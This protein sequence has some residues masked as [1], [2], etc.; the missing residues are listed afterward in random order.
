M[1]DPGKGVA[2]HNQGL[3]PI[4][5]G[6]RLGPY[7]VQEVIGQG[8]MGVVYRA[9]HAELERV[10]AVKVLQA[11]GPDSDSKARFQREAQAIAHM[12]HPNILNV[13]DFGEYGGTPYM[14]VEFVPGG[15]LADRLRSGPVDRQAALAFLRGIAE[16]LDYA[17]S[18]GIVHRDVKP[19]NVLLGP[20]D[21]P[22][23]ADFGLAKLLES[24]SIRSITGITTGT[25]AYMSPEQVT[26]SE[27]GPAADR[28]SLATIAYE[29]FTGAYPFDGEGVLEMLYAHVHRE[30]P[31]PSSRNPEL[32]PGVD[33]VI[34]RGLA[35]NPDERWHTCEA[36]VEALAIAVEAGPAAVARTAT[37]PLIRSVAPSSPQTPQAP[38][39]AGATAVLEPP[40]PATQRVPPPGLERTVAI[41]PPVAEKRKTRRSRYL[42]GAV[43]LMLLLLVAGYC[44]LSALNGPTL[45]LSPATARAGDRVVVTAGRV[46]ANQVGEIQLHSAV[47]IVPFRSDKNGKVSTILTV[48]SDTPIGDHTA[49]ICWGGSCH[50]QA[51]LRVVGAVALV[52]P[53]ATPS[54]PAQSQSPSPTASAPPTTAPAGGSSPSPTQAPAPKPSSQ[55]NPLPSPSPAPRPSPSP[56]PPPPPPAPSISVNP[57]HITL[58]SRTITVSGL[59]FGVNQSITISVVQG[60]ST[61]QQVTTTAASNGSFSKSMTVSTTVLTGSATIT[62]C[63]AGNACASQT[64]TVTLT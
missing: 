47:F 51:T 24:T 17:H 48:P 16:A 53:S 29:L 61:K 18:L 30:P 33:G 8:A 55:P 10:G 41:A 19:A 59:H 45:T 23:L 14:I 58:L 36:F 27:V 32:G 40:L 38:Q 57:S 56:T 34:L 63:D 52:G 6:T 7:E 60:G 62:A 21:T 11:I 50:A 22:I 37:A 26:G 5:P 35:K 15:S 2:T 4:E 9:Y 12:R 64:I 13:Y 20:D 3:L 54:A 43:A 31:P 49:R 1:M 28:Y 25:P 42:A 46:P 39:R 44:S